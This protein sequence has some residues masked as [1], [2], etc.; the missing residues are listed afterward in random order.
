[1]ASSPPDGPAVQSG[2]LRSAVSTLPSA[3]RTVAGPPAGPNPA[4]VRKPR[5]LPDPLRL[6]V[7][8]LATTLSGVPAATDAYEN[9]IPPR[10]SDPP[11]VTPAVARA[12][13]ENVP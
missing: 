11:A 6:I 5:V 9:V 13:A 2:E 12:C 1:M 3:Y 8:P 10:T 7:W 4:V